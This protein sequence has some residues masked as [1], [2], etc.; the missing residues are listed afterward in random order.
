MIS[1]LLPYY[2]I[3]AIFIF[4]GCILIINGTKGYRKEKIKVGSLIPERAT[5]G[6]IRYDGVKPGTIVTGKIAKFL[7]VFKIMLGIVII[8]IGILVSLFFFVS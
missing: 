4:F 7:G 5:L 1:E 8:L 2:I 3:P 6:L